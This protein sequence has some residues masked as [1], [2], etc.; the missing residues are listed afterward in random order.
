MSKAFIKK[1]ITVEDLQSATKDLEE[2]FKEDNEKYTHCLGMKHDVKLMLSSFSHESLLIWNVHIWAH[3][4]G[5]KWDAIFVGIIRKSEK[6][7]KKMMDEYLWLSKNSNAGIKLYKTAFDFAKSKGCEF[8][9]MN[10]IENH[11]LSNK[12]KKLYK[13]LGFEKDSETYF[14]KI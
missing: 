6:F 1:I 5:E 7:N 8:V 2:I 11:P 13:Y 14:K 4:N 9:S 3:F 10:V 12:I